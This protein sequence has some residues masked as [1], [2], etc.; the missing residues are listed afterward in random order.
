MLKESDLIN[1]KNHIQNTEPEMVNSKR[2][3]HL[4]MVD[5][6]TRNIKLVSYKPGSKFS[7]FM[8]NDV[9][10]SDVYFDESTN[11]FTRISEQHREEWFEVIPDENAEAV[12]DDEI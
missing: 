5:F 6:E 3:L 12:F 8:K 9:F 11:N 7:R 10:D 4:T 2:E 1:T